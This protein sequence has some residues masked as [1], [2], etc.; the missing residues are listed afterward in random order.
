MNTTCTR[1]GAP[2]AGEGEEEE[3]VGGGGG[4]DAGGTDRCLKK[5]K[6]YSFVMHGTAHP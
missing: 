3:V 1:L 2:A 5:E 4:D 6:S